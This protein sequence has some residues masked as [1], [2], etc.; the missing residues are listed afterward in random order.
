MRNPAKGTHPDLF[1]KED[2]PIF[3]PLEDLSEDEIVALPRKAF[4]TAEWDEL[5]EEMQWQ[6]Y[7]NSE[8]D[9]DRVRDL[10]EFLK[11]AYEYIKDPAYY[12]EGSE[13]EVFEMWI[14]DEYVIDRLVDNLDE[15]DDILETYQEQGFDEGE[16]REAL[17]EAVRNQ[18]NWDTRIDDYPSGEYRHELLGSIYIEPSQ[19]FFEDIAPGP[20]YESDMP[21]VMEKL[22]DENDEAYDVY[23]YNDAEET[24]WKMLMPKEEWEKHLKR[25]YEARKAKGWLKDETF[26]QWASGWNSWRPNIDI[27]DLDSGLYFIADPNWDY[28]RNDVADAIGA[29][30]E[31]GER[32]PRGAEDLEPGWEFYREGWAP[33]DTQAEEKRV[34]EG[35]EDG[36]YVAELS[37]GEL[38]KEGSAQGICTGQFQYGYPQKVQAGKI[39]ILSLRRP[40]GKPLLTFEVVLDAD[41]EPKDVIQIKGNGNRRPGFGRGS[42]GAGKFK[43]REVRL[44]MEIIK[45]LGLEP[46]KTTVVRHRGGDLRPG[47]ERLYGEPKRSNPHDF[48]PYKTFDDPAGYV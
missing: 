41:G 30:R 45:R 1:E 44:S 11:G 36:L 38:T 17:R 9:R 4:T 10:M 7:E 23:S 48:V 39:K 37:Y 20:Y 33:I 12:D 19:Y 42:Q 28:I 8:V 13:I 24:L 27:S 47:Y 16:I 14:D 26:D 15:A 5:D 35:L 46:E 3:V 22:K 6:I 21:M 2:T 29:E 34:I 25:D 43:E 31:P 18:N 32:V 40:S